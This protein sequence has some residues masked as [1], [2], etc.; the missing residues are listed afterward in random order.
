MKKVGILTF[1]A[2][3]NCG[4]MLQSYALQNIIKSIGNDV[5][6][7]DFSNKGQRELYGT[8][9]KNNSIK[10]LIKNLIILPHLK[11]I[12]KT[13]SEYKQFMSN[14]FRVSKS[15]FSDIHQLNENELQY[16]IYIA[17][18]DQI[19]N[20]TIDDADDA[21][22]LPFVSKK[23]KI[24]YAPSFGAKNPIKYSINYKKYAGYIKRFD[25][26]ST[27]EN[28]GRKWIKEMTGMDVP[29]VLDPTLLID[30]KEYDKIMT[31]V[32][33]PK[34]YIF[35]YAPGYYKNINKFVEKISEKY[36]IPVIVFNSKQYYIKRL[37]RRKMILSDIENP[38]AY[39]Y[40]MK[41][42]KLIITTSFHGTIFSSIFRKN[43][44]V[45]KNGEMYGDDDRVLTLVNGLGLEDRL[46]KPIFDKNFDYL[47]KV[48]Y[49]MYESNYYNLKEKSLNFLYNS[50]KYNKN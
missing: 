45:I 27:R 30:K 7:I 44:W 46:I 3:Y 33:T 2:G 29:V 26:L 38:S 8:F 13:R 22:F 28:N 43:F 19:W 31:P 1:H 21:Y 41:H 49:K 12:I 25:F 4:S 39:L 47:K 18:S 24:A 50:I 40:L 42:A 37:N 16:D 20:I 9:Y 17:G 11:K 15:E 48:N 10:N 5:E 32:T 14:N 6:I 36:H 35:Y 34:K 23:T